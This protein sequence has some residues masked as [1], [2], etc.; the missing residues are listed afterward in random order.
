[1]KSRKDKMASD[2]IKK[3]IEQACEYTRVESIQYIRTLNDLPGNLSSAYM[4]TVFRRAIFK[5][6]DK[7]ITIDF[8]GPRIAKEYAFGVFQER[9]ITK[10]SKQIHSELIDIFSKLLRIPLNKVG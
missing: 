10:A 9:F 1:M 5:V 2:L 4:E 8:T 6:T 3:K 7:A